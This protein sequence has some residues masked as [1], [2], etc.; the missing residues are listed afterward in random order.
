MEKITGSI[1]FSLLN[2]KTIGIVLVDTG[3]ELK[4]YIG[5]AIGENQKDD[6]KFIA[7]YGSPF[8]V[9]QAREMIE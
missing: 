8:P 5:T 1:W 7:K 2:G 4:A 3:F 9:Q 6:E